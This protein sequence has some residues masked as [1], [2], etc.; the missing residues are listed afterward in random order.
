MK[1][2][3]KESYDSIIEVMDSISH[4]TGDAERK[5]EYCN[6]KETKHS[7]IKEVEVWV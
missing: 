6:K 7:R 4:L 1:I 5:C 2:N 3:V